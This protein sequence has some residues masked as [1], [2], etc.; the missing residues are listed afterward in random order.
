MTLN[1]P[2]KAGFPFVDGL[3]LALESA[4]SDAAAIDLQSDY[5]QGGAS[6][7]SA[8]SWAH[9]MFKAEAKLEAFAFTSKKVP[10]M[11]LKEL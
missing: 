3:L 7:E 9:G 6:A 4:S 10:E 11:H 8:V 5:G 2:A 1:A